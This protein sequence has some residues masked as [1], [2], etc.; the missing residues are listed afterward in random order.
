MYLDSA[1][2]GHADLQK[3]V[4]KMSA[5]LALTDMPTKALKLRRH[6][7]MYCLAL[8][9]LTLRF[10]HT[11]LLKVEHDVVALQSGVRKSWVTCSFFLA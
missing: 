2:N 8:V 11:I 5:L 9:P 1:G 6:V 4:Q 7:L 10:S 3:S